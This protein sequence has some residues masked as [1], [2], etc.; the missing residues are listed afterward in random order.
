MATARFD[1]NGDGEDG[2]FQATPGQVLQLKLKVPAGATSVVFQVWDAGAANPALGIAANPPRASKGAP[3]LN[4]VGATTGKTV[5]PTTPNANVSLT[6]P[7]EAGHSYI[8]RCIRDGGQRL[9]GDRVVSD[10]ALIHERG[11]WI[12][13]A[14]GTRAPVATEVQQFESEGWAGALVD[15]MRAGIAGMPEDLAGLVAG[16]AIDWSQAQVFNG[17]I[18]LGTHFLAGGAPPYNITLSPNASR[19]FF[20]GAEGDVQSISGARK[21]RAIFCQSVFATM[22]IKNSATVI[23]PDGE[24][25]L[26]TP[27]N[28]FWLVGDGDPDG[29]GPWL[30]SITR[31]SFLLAPNAVLR[32]MASRF[33]DEVH[34]ADFMTE[35]ELSDAYHGTRLLDLQPAIQK[36]IDWVL[37]GA[38][39]A[40]KANGRVRLPAGILRIDRPI[41]VNYGTAYRSLIL[42]GE[43][44]IHGGEHGNPGTCIFA[45]FGDAMAIAVQTCS[46]VLIKSL[47]I[48]G[49]YSNEH[50]LDTIITQPGAMDQLD[51]QRWVDPRLPAS[52]SSRYAPY[53][54]IAIDPYSGPKPAVSYPDVVFPA[55]MEGTPQF[56]KSPSR[57]VS[58]ED[59]SITGFVVG[60]AL[61]PCQYDGSGDFVH[62]HRCIF[63]YCV[64]GWS[65][66]NSQA[67]CNTMKDCTFAN[68][69]T[70]FATTVHGQRIGNPQ[71]TIDGCSFETGIQLFEVNN[72]GYGQ[73]PNFQGCFAEAMYRL[74]IC[75]GQSAYAGALSFRNCEFGFSW[76]DRYGVP[77][78]VLEMPGVQQVTFEAVRFYNTSSMRGFLGFYCAQSSLPSSPAKQ[79]RLVSCESMAQDV[80]QTLPEKAAL[81]GTLGMVVALG[82]TDVDAYSMQTGYMTNLDSNAGL[83]N[84]LVA[85]STVAPRRFCANVYAR[86]L[87]SLWDGNDPGVDVAWGTLPLSITSV[88]STV[89]RVVTITIS[90]VT[91]AVL[92]HR[93]G[94][95]GDVVVSSAT[96]AAFVVTARTGTTLTLRALTGFNVS[97]N[98]F[99]SIVSGANL[100][101]PINCRRYAIEA[102]L[103]GDTTSGSAVVS[104]LTLGNGSAPV[105]EDILTAND[106]LY[107]N[108]DVDQVI[109]P[110]DGSARL[111]S[112]NTGARTATF[113]GNFNYTQT[114]RRFA[115]FVRPAMP[116]A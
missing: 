70:A 42:E 40:G 18:V 9:A 10:P 21:G 96:G 7:N 95:V 101:R 115:I 49:K 86:N 68:V 46:H 107:V 29:N 63:Y 72:L 93:G 13:T 56:N 114:R 110:E 12:P 8:I 47:S 36:A 66:G 98:L 91:A 41:N 62:L 30:V 71:I 82:S 23:T 45:N 99:N 92:A 100:L 53:A 108:Q 25:F 54:G 69:H 104:N 52:A 61:Q 6:L 79:L 39:G 94:D 83:F 64:Y 74:G 90:G 5:S 14:Y 113:A 97:G 35:A 50:I 26:C 109:N 20:L 44:I 43:G 11:V 77:T 1:I 37:F 84:A 27:R 85:E 59:V 87:R 28:S 32:T 19:L 112:F 55:G 57:H 3:A 65:W 67:R 88:V 106:Y 16:E 51:P 103:Y 34:V 78:W 116:N 22:R 111:V 48:V 58:I 17:G 81:N 89:G 80:A 33:S 75:N 76:W 60:V 15:H 73:G 24:D 38:L 2:G 31:P 102:V 105:L 4:L